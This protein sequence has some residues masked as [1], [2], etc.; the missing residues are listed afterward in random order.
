MKINTSLLHNFSKEKYLAYIKSLPNFRQERVQSYATIILTLS[1]ICLFG[2]FAIAPTLGTISTLNKTLSDHKFLAD[3]LQ[4]KIT[5]M[6]TLQ[7]QYLSLAPRLSIL[8]AA[9]PKT[10]GTSTIAGKLRALANKSRLTTLQLSVSDIEVATSKKPGNILT[11]VSIKAVFQGDPKDFESFAKQLVAIDRL[12]TL[13]EIGL[14]RQ[15]TQ[16]GYNYQL[17]LSATAY[18][19]P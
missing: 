12:I 4:T 14:S 15:K 11:P 17:N 5:S 16:D 1:A 19:K 3:S 10:P 18:Y 13:D 7:S 2:L 9:I 6:S 8:Y